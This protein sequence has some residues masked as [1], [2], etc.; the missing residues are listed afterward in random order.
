MIQLMG[1]RGTLPVSGPRYVKY[2]GST[3]SVF[4]PVSDES[5][6][7]IDG[8]T[9]IYKINKFNQFKDYHIFLTH[10][11]WDHIVGLPTFYPFFDES[12]SIT[13][14]LEDKHTLHSKDF[15]KVLFNP[16]FFPVPRSMLKAKIKINLIKGAQKFTFGNVNIESAEGHHPNGALMYKINDNGLITLFATD[17]EHGSEVDDFLIEFAYLSDYFIFDTTYLPEDYEGSRD[18]I[19]KKGWGHSTYIYGTDFAKKAKVKNLVL[20]HHNP[21]YD[22]ITLEEMEIVAKKDFPNTIC[23]YDQMEIK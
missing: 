23:G 1:C 7:I 14:Y 10:L 18:G 8:G 12:K 2:G 6:V 16:P 22:D 13:L 4:I 9:G 5:C 15:L 21:D 3:P 20:Y 17:Y 11:H 19:S